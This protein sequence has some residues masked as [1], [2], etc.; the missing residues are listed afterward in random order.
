MKKLPEPLSK[1]MK[2]KVK[3]KA[4]LV[5]KLSETRKGQFREQATKLR[6]VTLSKLC[7]VVMMRCTS[8]SVRLDRSRST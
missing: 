8:T 1:L 2:T 4:R 5:A 3:V 6:K 7:Q